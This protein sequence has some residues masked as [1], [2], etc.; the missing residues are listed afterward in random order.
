[1]ILAFRSMPRAVLKSHAPLV[2]IMSAVLIA[3]QFFVGSAAAPVRTGELTSRQLLI[4]L[5]LCFIWLTLEVGLVEEFFFR[6]LLQARL[7]AYFRSEVT[8]VVLMSLI[9]GFAH[10]PGFVLL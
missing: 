1:V 7:A 10:V 4:G 6:A 2:L 9:F 8:G 3:F 5:P